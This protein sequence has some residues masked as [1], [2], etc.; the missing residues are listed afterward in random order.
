ME[1][2]LL[3]NPSM[4]VPLFHYPR[5]E[6]SSLA[7]EARY[8]EINQELVQSVLD[9]LLGQKLSI[10]TDDSCI[11]QELLWSVQLLVT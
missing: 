10:N 7:E 3:L 2:N 1:V 6:V 11:N 9:L 8:D 5:H 4:E